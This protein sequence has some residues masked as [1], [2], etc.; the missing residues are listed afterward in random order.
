VGSDDGL[1]EVE[2]VGTPSL[3]RRV[4]GYQFDAREA[5]LPTVCKPHSHEAERDTWE[6]ELVG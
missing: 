3:A 5:L 6:R 1:T 2:R 4:H